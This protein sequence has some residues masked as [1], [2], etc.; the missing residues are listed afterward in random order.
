MIG[1][2]TGPTGDDLGIGERIK[3]WAPVSALG[4]ESVYVVAS[5]QAL[6]IPAVH[7][8]ATAAPA[9]RLPW[10]HID[11]VHWEQPYLLIVAQVDGATR[12]WRIDLAEPRSLPEFVRERV[13]ATIIVSEHIPLH[14]DSGVRLIARRSNP[15][16]PVEWTMSF[17]PGLDGSDPHIQSAAQAALADLRAV[18]GI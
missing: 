14:D 5:A 13:M 18:F 7:E 9:V 6:Y 17:D 12:N 4:G 11:R 16:S 10:T 2:R 3:S 8:L 1:K 15:N